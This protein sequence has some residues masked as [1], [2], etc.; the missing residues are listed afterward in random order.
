MILNL[1]S[2]GRN[3]TGKCKKFTDKVYLC[4]YRFQSPETHH[5]DQK[6]ADE[7]RA[8]NENFVS[9]RYRIVN[10]WLWV[11]LARDIKRKRSTIRKIMWVETPRQSAIYKVVMVIVTCK[12]HSRAMTFVLSKAQGLIFM[13]SL[14]CNFPSISFFMLFFL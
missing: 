10:L 6:S 13:N 9:I 12:T 14:K 5:E 2:Q 7:H 11:W 8:N 4:T 3:I 1:D